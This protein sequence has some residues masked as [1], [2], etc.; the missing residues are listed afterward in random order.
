[1]ISPD[2]SLVTVTSR[3]ARGDNEHNLVSFRVTNNAQTSLGPLLARIWIPCAP[4]NDPGPFLMASDSEQV[5]VR[6]ETTPLDGGPRDLR[7]LEDKEDDQIRWTTNS[8]DAVTLDPS[9]S[10]TFTVSGFSAA[11]C[12]D[13]GASIRVVLTLK[14]KADLCDQQI[15][16]KPDK[17]GPTIHFFDASPEFVLH[18]GGDRVRLLCSATDADKVILY[19]NNERSDEAEVSGTEPIVFFDR[20]SITTVY[21]IEAR[22]G[23]RSVWAQETVHLAQPG[24]NR[25][26]VPQGYPALLLPA[27]DG[28]TLF[29]VFV[30]TDGRASLWSSAT[31][32]AGWQPEDAIDP[33]NPA[34]EFPQA[35][36]H[37]AGVFFGNKVW[38]IGGSSVDADVVSNNVYCYDPLGRTWSDL[39]ATMGPPDAF[40]PRMGH[41][42]V[43]FKNQIW[44]LGGVNRD[45]KPLN[46][47]WSFDPFNADAS[48][49]WTSNPAALWS[50]RCMFAAAVAAP[51]LLPGRG[52]MLWIYGGLSNPDVLVP[53]EGL[54][55]TEDGTTWARQKNF[56]MRPEPGVARG[57]TLLYNSLDG[58]LLLAGTF[59]VSPSGPG[60][61]GRLESHVF[62]L[63]TDRYLWEDHP[64][65][66]GWEQ[67]GGNPFLIR[68]IV[69]NG[70]VFFWSIYSA[71]GRP[72]RLNIFIPS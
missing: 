48:K 2:I 3:V 30:D 71:I 60:A 15:D 43:V 5:T 28:N 65:S 32:F 42:C 4:S 1:M 67:F 51:G 11:T 64:V 40:T 7:Q 13:A 27:T 26:A 68:S 19:K 14:G 69:F 18:A 6:C 36:K 25:Q 66:W 35:M 33:T 22:A 23:D 20:P 37:S 31:G 45:G 16:V 58:H 29:G 39:T 55:S 61:A 12:G 34:V 59:L 41:A 62:V 44:V 24:W 46:D 56:E 54:W 57:A 17:G 8:L 47:V 10:M 38:L 52:E 70:F 53:E 49:R 9:G 50:P 72:P 21:K 63:Q